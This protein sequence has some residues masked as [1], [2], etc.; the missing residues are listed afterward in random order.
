MNSATY[1]RRSVYILLAVAF[2]V[3]VTVYFLND[4]FHDSLLPAL[5]I[6]QPLGDAV[7]SVLIVFA[8]AVAIRL[9]SYAFFHDLAMGE[10]KALV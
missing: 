9:V 7:G 3:G 6:P 8:V 1:L 4:W 2:A 10:D 5:G